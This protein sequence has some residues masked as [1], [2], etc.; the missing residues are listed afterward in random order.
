MRE[1][2]TEDVASFDG[3]L[4]QPRAQLVLAQAVSSGPGRRSTSAAADR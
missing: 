4:V 2:W 3:E 1:M